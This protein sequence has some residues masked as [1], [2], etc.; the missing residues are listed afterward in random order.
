LTLCLLQYLAHCAPALQTGILQITDKYRLRLITQLSTE[1]Y[2]QIV[3][4][5]KRTIFFRRQTVY[6]IFK[7]VTIA[8]V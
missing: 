6:E 7:A 1:R 2:K 3:S 5:T 4:V 8:V